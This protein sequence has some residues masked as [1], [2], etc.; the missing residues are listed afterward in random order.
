MVLK[1]F[2]IFRIEKNVYQKRNSGDFGIKTAYWTSIF[3]IPITGFVLTL[4]TSKSPFMGSISFTALSW[5]ED[6]YRYSICNRPKNYFYFFCF[7]FLSPHPIVFCAGLYPSPH[8]KISAQEILLHFI[9]WEKK[10]EKKA[11]NRFI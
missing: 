4:M 2:Q 11:K 8:L 7:G 10:K 6:V 5:I 9:I 1:I 3:I